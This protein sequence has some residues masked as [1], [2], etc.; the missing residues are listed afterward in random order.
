MRTCGSG[1]GAG[2][3]EAGGGLP[4][5][6]AAGA[7]VYVSVRVCVGA[8]V[9]GGARSGLDAGRGGAAAL[10]AGRGPGTRVPLSSLWEP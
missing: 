8:G 5:V 9:L 6:C 1:P 7:S 10:R 2:C 4:G 3:V